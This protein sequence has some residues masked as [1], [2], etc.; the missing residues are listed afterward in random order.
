MD[1]LNAI[2]DSQQWSGDRR[3]SNSSITPSIFGRTFSKSSTNGLSLVDK[4]GPLGLNTLHDPLDAV[5]DLIFVHGL[6]GGSQST[7]TE[8]QNGAL[9][10]ALYW[11][12]RWLPHEDGFGDVRIHSFGYDSNWAK[13]STLN[14]HDFA[15]S[16]LVAIMDCPAINE[17][18]QAKL[19]RIPLVFAAH[20]MGGLVVKKAYIIAR[21]SREYTMIATRTKAMFFLA[22]P[23]RGS[24]LA[25]TFTKILNLTFGNRP[26]VMDL[27]RNS[28][29][30]QSINDEFPTLC[31]ELQLYSFYE[32]M[33]TSIG[34]TKAIIVQRDMAT[35]GYRNERTAYLNADHRHIVKFLNPE[36][37]NYKTVRNALAATIHS[38]RHEALLIDSKNDLVALQDQLNLCLGIS[39]APGDELM[40]VESVRMPGSCEWIL[41]KT[42]F[43]EWRNSA[44]PW[45]Y[46]VSAR[47]ATGKSVLCGFVIKHLKDADLNCCYYFFTHG[48]KDKS[49]ITSCLLSLAWQMAVAQRD[50]METIIKICS[51]DG[52]ISRSI[53]YRTVWRK[54]FVEGILRLKIQ[55]VYWV[56]DALDECKE[57]AELV[58]YLLKLTDTCD[59][60][61]FVT[62]RRRFE[63]PKNL[64]ALK[65][66]VCAETIG[67][68]DTKSDIALYLQDNIHNLPQS[69][70]VERRVMVDTILE[71]SAGC[72]LWVNLVL[73]QL[74]NVQT[75][76][77]TQRILEE[78]P[79]DMDD[80]YTRILT[81]MSDEPQGN[82]MAKAILD[83]VVCSARPM[84]IDEL[85]NALELDLD[86]SIYSV[87]RAIETTCGQLVYVDIQSRVH[88]I[89]QTAKEYLLRHKGSEFSISRKDGHKRLALMCLKY[90][91]GPDI[92]GVKR[93]P[94][95]SGA[96]PTRSPF[97]AYASKYLSDHITFIDSTDDEFI[98]ALATFLSSPNVLP[99]IEYLASQQ[100]LD[101]LIQT[102][103]SLTHLLR[104]RS[105]LMSLLGHDVATIN[106]WS[107]DLIRL[108]TKFG[109]SL[110]AL[111]SSIFNLIPPFCP[112]ESAIRRQFGNSPRDISVVGLS[113]TAW[114]DCLSTIY[115]SNAIVTA[116]ASSD[117]FF[118]IGLSTGKVGIYQET[119]CQEAKV[120][121]CGEAVRFIEFSTSSS[122]LATC[123][124]K[125]LQIW[126]LDSW[127]QT[128]NFDLR[129][130]CMSV[131]FIEE[132]Q[133]LLAAMRN[134]ELVE[135]NLQTGDAA[136]PLEWT[137]DDEGQAAKTFRRPS[138]VVMS[139]SQYQLA[140]IYRGQDILVWDLGGSM[141]YE[142]YNK[143][144][145]LSMS[146]DKR[147]NTT[148]YAV[149]FNPAP[150]STLFAVSYFE[151]DIVIFDTADGS[152]KESVEAGA[153]SLAVSPNG[154]T[155]AS[156]DS[157]GVVQ[158]FD[159]ET[160]KPFFRIQSRDWG[161]KA[162][163]FNGDGSRLLVGRGSQCKIWNPVALLRQDDDT[164]NSD[165]VSVS[166]AAQEFQ[167][168]NSGDEIL[169]TAICEY[170]S[171]A[172]FLCGKSDGSVSLYSTKDGKQLKVLY[173]HPDGASILALFVDAKSPIVGSSAASGRIMTHKL[174]KVRNE[175]QVSKA[176]FDLKP[177]FAIEQILN[178]EG[179]TRILVCSP[180]VDTLYE[181][182]GGLN[183]VLATRKRDSAAP[184]RWAALPNKRDVILITGHT[185]H[186][187]DWDKLCRLT[188]DTGIILEGDD[189]LGAS[190]ESITPCYNGLV[191]ATSFSHFRQAH[192]KCYNLLLYPIASFQASPKSPTTARPKSP[193]TTTA[194]PVPNSLFL[195][196]QVEYLIG[197][198]AKRLIFLDASGW[199]CSTDQQTFAVTRHFFVPA[200][201]LSSNLELMVRVT[202]LGDILF[203]RGDEVAVIKRGLDTNETGA[204]PRV[205]R[206][207]PA[208]HGGRLSVG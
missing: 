59:V 50:I 187:F 185:A 179:H 177:G 169:I 152:R 75:V 25:T 72:F 109:S 82:N 117:K 86:D 175:W 4:K 161:I 74:S 43:S 33:P 124:I 163:C 97:V 90:L 188:G 81:S 144:T 107:S 165:T 57:N 76:S 189:S 13:E 102:G 5:A 125:K 44:S 121:D 129:Q 116:I 1:R 101:R 53:D 186:I 106:S 27:H 91:S 63:A 56:L 208:R 194:K 103:N 178:N 45:I 123:G 14:I 112:P 196:S 85:H 87:A 9:D 49:R 136:E 10:P 171:G 65:A 133:I 92:G 66:K 11:P 167:Y 127:T 39:E 135:Y 192:T 79:S 126:S 164:D 154:R 122:V 199:I 146:K 173:K 118:A 128:W 191:I 47:P 202:K 138:R 20:S 160:L 96:V 80:L 62:H 170:D 34:V 24:D 61:V 60:R 131:I 78:T 147:Q 190:I 155:L 137:I 153:Q 23:H 204:W 8:S 94:N 52:S 150:D 15:K 176:Q 58:A 140:G 113:A 198:Y 149:V 195:S 12:E 104:R 7:W 182:T 67:S 132:N 73:Q 70:D 142:T 180:G 197:P 119:T 30:T 201:W 139:A 172:V 193:T 71:K 84:T 6:G 184:H 203:V 42:V 115:F 46:W 16:L 93:R 157:S 88:V 19:S 17:K 55:R 114:D 206:R 48:D 105:K 41:K 183:T 51:K 64:G 151:G 99:W 29:I 22:T 141:M 54:L 3:K 156:F 159:F 205:G 130:M 158:V 207:P 2:Q 77:D 162:L 69:T 111:P 38:F 21:A 31:E 28:Q 110:T 108:A 166:T 32:T 145:G 148:M 134:N 83:W 100:N 143:D 200:D 35:L 174:T 37:V 26:F 89:H 168:D 181:M 18:A 98:V 36:D 40:A 68:D 95:A 120:L